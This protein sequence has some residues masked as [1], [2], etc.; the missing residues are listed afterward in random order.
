ME[1]TLNALPMLAFAVL[2]AW[3]VVWVNR[4]LPVPAIGSGV[5]SSLIAWSFRVVVSG[6][7]IIVVA[8]P[9]L[10]A[11]RLVSVLAG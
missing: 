1:P 4:D 7:A 9:L 10:V 3:L 2:V 8:A 11:L 6:V 5:S